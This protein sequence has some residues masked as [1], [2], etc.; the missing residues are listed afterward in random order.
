[1]SMKDKPKTLVFTITDLAKEFKLTTRAI[2]FYEDQ[3]LLNP[4][5][6]GRKR[7]YGNRDRTR[8]KLILR[9]KRL[10]F[11]LSET[12]ELFELFDSPRGEERQLRR[13]VKILSER[14]AIL[15]QQQRDIEAI[16]GEIE[17]AEAECVKLLGEFESSR[18]ES[19]L[20]VPQRSRLAIGSGNG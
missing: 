3:G 9:G 10:G 16:L 7:V 20:P 17:V 15:E 12:R 6:E 5:R 18:E 8:L 14:R 13:F 11:S 1:L 4:Q 19:N 2:R